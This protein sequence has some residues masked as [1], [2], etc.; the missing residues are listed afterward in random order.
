MAL[1]Q[2]RLAD[3][4]IEHISQHSA[5]CKWTFWQSSL[6]QTPYP[7]L[8][9]SVSTIFTIYHQFLHSHTITASHSN[10]TTQPIDSSCRSARGGYQTMNIIQ[11]NI[12]CQWVNTLSSNVISTV[13]K[14]SSTSPKTTS[15]ISRERTVETL[16]PQYSTN[17]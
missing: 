14:I 12:N 17:S 8:T 11:A 13:P 15:W 6:S 9:T 2:I 16:F 5:T 10:Q 4:W 3:P 1:I 7:C